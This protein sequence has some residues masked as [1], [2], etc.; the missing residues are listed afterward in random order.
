MPLTLSGNGTISDLASAPTV[1]GTAVAVGTPSLSSLGIDNHDNITVDNSGRMTNSSQPVFQGN[2]VGRQAV[3]SAG[4]IDFQ[5]ISNPLNNGNNWDGTSTFTCPVT[6]YY[7]CSYQSMNNGGQTSEDHYIE[8]H[9]NNSEAGIWTYCSGGDVTPTHHLHHGFTATVYCSANDTIRFYHV[10]GY[11]YS[12]AYV[13][14]LITL[15]S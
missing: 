9:V 2:R 8:L 13:T 1:G 11:T 10:G 5:A 15:I 14:G 6:G 3:N 12:G 4:Y 7:L